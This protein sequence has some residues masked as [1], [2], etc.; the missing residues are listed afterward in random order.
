MRISILVKIIK[1]R[2]GS[3]TRI[4]REHPGCDGDI[5]FGISEG[6]NPV[7]GVRSFIVFAT[8]S[9]KEDAAPVSGK[10]VEKWS[11][12]SQA[13][14]VFSRPFEIQSGANSCPC[15]PL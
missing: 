2:K 3:V 14:T 15:M 1:A 5:L 13:G 4:P 11:E 10:E 7:F 8:R 12:G 6:L 9:Q